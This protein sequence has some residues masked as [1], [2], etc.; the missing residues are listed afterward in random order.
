MD[1]EMW[2]GSRLFWTVFSIRDNCIQFFYYPTSNHKKYYTICFF[3][4]KKYQLRAAVYCTV[5]YNV[6]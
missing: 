3:I 2:P 6:Q 1:Q 5:L 4:M